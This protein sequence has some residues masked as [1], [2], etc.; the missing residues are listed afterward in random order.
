MIWS[1][2]GAAGNSECLVARCSNSNLFKVA[3]NA[4]FCRF[5][6]TGELDLLDPINSR[7]LRD[8]KASELIAE[9]VSCRRPLHPLTCLWPNLDHFG[10]SINPCLRVVGQRRS[11]GARSAE[12]SQRHPLHRSLAWHAGDWQLRQDFCVGSIV[13]K[14]HHV[15][16]AQC[17]A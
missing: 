1:P 9:D 16:P 11:C 4:L 14:P 10:L 12:L 2:A 5:A 17:P 6:P 7:Q 13:G 15:K 3:Y 8:L